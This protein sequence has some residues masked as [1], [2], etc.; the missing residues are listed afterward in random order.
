MGQR[1]FITVRLV[2]AAVLVAALGAGAAVTWARHRQAEH[3]ATAVIMLHPL[4]GNA[5]SPGG[6]GDDL[7]N[8]ET[9]AQVLRSDAVARAVLDRL[10]EKGEPSD[11]LP[12][13]SVS[14]PPNTQL[15]DITARGPDDATAVARASAFADVYLQFRRSRT[16]SAVYERTSR[17]EEL[18]SLREDERDAA[19]AR[20]D[21]LPQ[22]APE[23]QLL[24]QQVQEVVVQISSLRAQLAGAQAVGLDPGQLVTPGQVVG[25]GP[26]A[27]PLR[28]GTLGAL[29]GLLVVLFVGMSRAGR[30]AP[31]VVRGL[32][33][34]DDDGP[35]PL[36][37]VTAPVRADSD[38]IAQVRS[39]VLAVGS[40]RPPVVTVALPG[41]E[42]PL[43]FAALA[44]S[45][46]RARYEVVTVDLALPAVVAAMSELVLQ[47]AVVDDVLVADGDFHSRLH[48]VTEASATRADFADLAASAEMRRSLAELAKR[49]DL[50]LVRSP[51]LATPVGRALLAASTAVVVEFW[52]HV[53]T[54]AEIDTVLVEAERVSTHVVGLVE[55]D[56]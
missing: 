23:R 15:L 4:E 56:S 27:S 6:R 45:L 9:E 12:S 16:E 47:D 28:A 22:A 19:V 42:Y 44:E 35:V 29:L 8:L 55:V 49:A 5:Y 46:T 38:V 20:L 54:R 24:E 10:G 41:R 26:W 30:T 13:V 53:S 1:R 2:L 37:V 39:A 3:V 31:D 17:L 32:A 48:P 52:P 34:L 21:K 25:A 33:D 7:V 51:G 14:V 50:V 40:D 11:L 36:G 18:V 43:A